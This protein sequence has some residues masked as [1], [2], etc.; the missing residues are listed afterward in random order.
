MSGFLIDTNVLSEL[1]KGQRCNP[2]VR[3]WFETAS[4]ED[5]YLSVLVL[6][7]IR[8]G[9]ER[10]RLHDRSSASALEKW[11]TKLSTDFSDRILP[12]DQAVANQW[13]QLGVKQPAPV[14]DALLAATA[15]VH[16][17]TV[18][19]RDSTGFKNTGARVLNPFEYTG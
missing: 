2:A 19:T 3:Q 12:V 15:M 1:R 4:G 5:L 14:L 13:G 17:L 11:L 7:E 9:I 18:V 16:D 8:R 10:I 6:G